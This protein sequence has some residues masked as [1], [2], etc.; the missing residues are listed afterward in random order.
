MFFRGENRS[1][2]S[3][4]GRW[5]LLC[6]DIRGWRGGENCWWARVMRSQVRFGSCDAAF[7]NLFIVI[8]FSVRCFSVRA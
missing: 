4:F 3:M 7:F 8:L 2:Q 5:I 6:A 1:G